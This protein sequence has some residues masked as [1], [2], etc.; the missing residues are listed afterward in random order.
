M[1]HKQLKIVSLALKNIKE[2]IESSKHGYTLT[3]IDK[4]LTI[5]P[6]IFVL[7]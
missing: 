6:Q 1:Q 7:N 4:I 5:P 2:I 3:T